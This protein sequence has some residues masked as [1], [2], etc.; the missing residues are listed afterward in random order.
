MYV[1]CLSPL[2]PDDGSSLFVQMAASYAASLAPGTLLN[3]KKQAEEYLKF[4]IIYRVPYLAPSTTHACMYAQLLA[5]RHAA[6]TSIKNYLSGAKTWVL[7]HGGCIDAFMSH[8]LGQ[9][10]KGFTKNS[11]HI[12]SRAAPLNVEHIKI[13]CDF[14]DYSVNAPLA[15]KPA[16]L[17]GYSCFLRGSNLLSPNML[18]WGGPHTLLAMD[19][20]DVG[21]H[22]S[23]FIRST[24]TKSGPTGFSFSLPQG[25]ES[26]YCPV[27]AWR[28]YKA[29]IRPWA[30]G[31]AFL[32]NNKLPL[33]PRQ[34]VGLMRLALKDRTD[35]CSAHI[36]MHSLRRGATHTAVEQGIPLETIQQRGTW[37]SKSGMTPYL[38]PHSCSTITVP[39]SNLAN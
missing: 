14:L 38:A 34:L 19:V 26:T 5:N 28:H 27:A 4:A 16:V 23:I 18:E 2:L 39:V 6:P 8:Q 25:E 21:P 3:R 20:K 12:P 36:T 29:A 37:K 1:T 13:I 7:E 33:T 9:L 10:V 35:V 15:A 31:P 30:L 32:N 22:L 11:S 17:L 24:K